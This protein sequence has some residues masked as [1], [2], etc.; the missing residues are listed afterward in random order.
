MKKRLALL[1]VGALVLL[2]GLDTEAFGA[3]YTVSLDPNDW[4]PDGY[5][6]QGSGTLT[7][8]PEGYLRGTK[9]TATGGSDWALSRQTTS[10]YDFQDATLRYQWRVNGLDSYS[11]IVTG[12]TSV[13]VFDPYPK[14]KTNYST[15][16][17]WDG[18]EVIADDTW[19]YSEVTFSETHY[20]YTVSYLGYGQ[21][22]FLSGT[23]N[24]DASRWSALQ[25]NQFWFRLL[26]NY[27]EGVYFDLA[28]A[29]IETPE[30][31]PEPSALLVWSLLSGL[32]IGVGWRRRKPQPA[33][34]TQCHFQPS[35]QSAARL[36]DYIHEDQN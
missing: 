3:I 29:T 12:T 4:E 26:D 20:D 30:L 27:A 8:T 23:E 16:H 1:M 32:V 24:I 15:H 9:T 21:T 36:L 17:S 13:Y 28:Q 10:V 14:K 22:D 7:Q 34:G 19:L 35:S 33:G 2:V 25:T 6:Y 18:S 5:A 11:A 31:V